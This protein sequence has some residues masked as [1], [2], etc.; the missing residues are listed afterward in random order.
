[1]RIFKYINVNDRQAEVKERIIMDGKINAIPLRIEYDYYVE[2]NLIY[3]DTSFNE[4]KNTIKQSMQQKLK[5]F[6][7]GN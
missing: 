5:E 1:M 6:M 2:G 4:I 7:N 3:R